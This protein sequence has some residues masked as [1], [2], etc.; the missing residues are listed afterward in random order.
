MILI[1]EVCSDRL[2]YFE[3]VKPIENILKKAK[4]DIFAKH[5]MKLNQRDLEAAEKIVICGTALK[6][7]SYSEDIDQFNWMEEFHRPILGI[8]A[9]MQILA[10]VFGSSLIEN[11]RIGQYKVKTVRK[12]S[13]TSKAEFRSY[14]LNSKAA[15]LSDKFE[16]LGESGRLPCMIKHKD[17]EFY[18]CLF[19]PEVLNPEI[20]ENFAGT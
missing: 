11:V 3:F 15:G 1:I 7:F 10:R 4:R 16:V 5:Y 6:D 14:F 2:S 9:G 12:S 20:I 8:C 19:H 13:L 17:R 18:G